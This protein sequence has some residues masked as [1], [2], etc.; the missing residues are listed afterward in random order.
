MSSRKKSVD[1]L[2]MPKKTITKRHIEFDTKDGKVEFYGR[3]KPERRVR[4]NFK[5]KKD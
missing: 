3:R 5:A 2:A 4:V 1:F